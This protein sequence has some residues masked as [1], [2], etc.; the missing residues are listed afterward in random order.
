MKS[1]RKSIPIKVGKIIIGGKAPISVESMIKAKIY[2]VKVVVNQ[3]KQLERIGCEIIRIA[4]PDMETAKKI[5]MIKRKINIPLIADIHFNYRLALEVITQGVDGIRLN[6]GNIKNKEEIKIIVKYAQEYKIPIRV[7]VN[8]GSLDRK[9]FSEVNSLS[10]VNSALEYINILE[11]L[12]FYQI[13]V[14]VKSANI[15]TMTKAYELLAKKVDY[16]FHVGVTEAGP[17]LSGSIKSA[18][19]I[20]ILL[21]QGIGDTIRVS[22][23]DTAIEEVKTA[24]RILQSLGLRNYEHI[25][26]SCPTCGRCNVDLIKIVRKV[27]KKIF[28][29]KKTFKIAIMGCVV[30]GP[31]EAKE[32]DIG[33]A[34]GK[35]MGILFKKGKIIKKIKE[36]EM[37]K[38]L[39]EEIKKMSLE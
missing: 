5:S 27:E 20:G 6:P 29:I 22:L 25:I 38:V 2:D 7:G 12:G 9:K 16:P 14:S 31:G 1:R 18:V 3:I 15:L 11:S 23:T 35:K 30:N 21:S 17:L 24:Y 28:K 37:D 34:A 13:I 8:S 26:I 33:I 10:L 39:I 32:A 4:V 19:G 36:E